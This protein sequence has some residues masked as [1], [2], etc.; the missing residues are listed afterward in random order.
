M[1]PRDRVGEASG[2][3]EGQGH[4]EVKRQKAEVPDKDYTNEGQAP[5]GVIQS[6]ASLGFPGFLFVGRAAF[7]RSHYGARAVLLG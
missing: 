2:T 5:L 7:R 3:C 4:P 1:E 6:K